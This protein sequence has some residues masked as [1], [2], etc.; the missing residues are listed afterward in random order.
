[1]L[2]AWSFF[3]VWNV[4]AEASVSANISIS[5]AS[6]V[7][8]NSGTATL[9]IS[10]NEHIGQIYGTFAC[11]GLG[12]KDLRYSVSDE[13]VTSKS[14]TISWKASQV[15]TFTCEVTGLE[16]GTLESQAWPSVSVAAKTIQVI[17][18]TTNKKPSSGSSSSNGSSTGGTT[19]DK[20]EYSSDND[21]S[22]LSVEG[23]EINPVF[24]KAT[25]EYRLAVDER[26]EK[27]NIIARA[28]HE[29]A[30]VAGAGEIQLSAGE[31]TIEIKVTAEN[32]NEKVYKL[33]VIVEDQ[34]PISVTV[35]EKKYTVVKK[36]NDL[37][38]KLEYYEEKIIKIENQDVVAYENKET[39]V[40]LVILKDENNKLG[41]YIYNEQTGKYSEY[42]FITFG[43]ITLQ[44][45]DAPSVLKNYQKDEI[46][47]QDEKIII[48]K[49]DLAYKVGL[50]YGTNVKTGNTG[51]YVY[52]KNE[53]TLSKYYDEEVK[54]YKNELRKQKNYL[55]MLM[56]I[57]AFIGIILIIISI[58]KEKKR[59]KKRMIHL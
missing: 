21:L 20:K 10:S 24:D 52:D 13:P 55:M 34:N 46:T 28:N 44:L 47:I 12:Q 48:Y 53:E 33:I 29:K 49:I 26:V 58:I 30:T 11:G 14:Y 43:N 41:Y 37:L 6:T 23:Y 2:L 54:F 19:A 16:V 3:P 35:G 38:E 56:G 40:T 31:N 45:L 25:T 5:T 50:I 57:V 9:T 18:A 7:V 22:S 27:L 8:G 39:K 59:R 17:G 51:Y 15:G 36:N 4:D 32:G 42:H 1:M